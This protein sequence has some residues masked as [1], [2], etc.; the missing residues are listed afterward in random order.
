MA[1]ASH[2]EF[3]GCAFA[4]H[5]IDVEVLDV[6]LCMLKS[7]ATV[8]CP[9]QYALFLPAFCLSVGVVSVREQSPFTS[10]Q[11]QSRR[12]WI[13]LW[14]RSDLLRF[15]YG[16]R[17]FG[18]RCHSILLH[19]SSDHSSFVRVLYWYAKLRP[20]LPIYIVGNV[21]THCRLSYSEVANLCFLCTLYTNASRW[22]Y[23]HMFHFDY[24]H[25]KY[26]KLRPPLLSIACNSILFVCAC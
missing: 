6:D 22:F 9:G 16:M 25:V 23:A 3:C 17:S 19:W 14:R 12:G 13:I 4:L 10:W 18:F 15:S 1:S 26:A 5:L 11:H 8:R 24:V 20:P 21:T 7:G 2:T